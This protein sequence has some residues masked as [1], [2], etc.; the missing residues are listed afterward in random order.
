M[1]KMFRTILCIGVFLG[2]P[3]STANAVLE[4]R[5]GGQAY[6]DTELNIT[7]AADA[8]INGA[9]DWWAQWIWASGLTIGGVSGW[10]LPSAEGGFVNE[11]YF[12]YWNEGITAATPGV[13]SNVQSS[14]YW[15][16]TEL[17]ED[18]PYAFIFFFN[19]GY[20]LDDIKSYP[21][22]AWAVHDGDVGAGLVPE[23]EM[24]AMMFIGLLAMFGFIRL[25]QQR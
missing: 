8:N 17:V 13:F 9:H 4:S 18:R 7:W 23:P 14:V 12:L 22:F 11:M 20:T 2:G 25:R 16:G 24:Y 15:S 3:I 19:S 10:R 6:Y 21:H 5:L 1:I